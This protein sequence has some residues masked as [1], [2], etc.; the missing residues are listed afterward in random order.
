V[1]YPDAGQAADDVV[2]PHPETAASPIDSKTTGA[3]T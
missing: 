3:A 1:L 2:I